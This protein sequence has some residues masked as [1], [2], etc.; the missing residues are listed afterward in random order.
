MDA[1]I[2]IAADSVFNS[3]LTLQSRLYAQINNGNITLD[4]IFRCT[5]C[6][7]EAKDVQLLRGL[8][9]PGCASVSKQLTVSDDGVSRSHVIQGIKTS[10]FRI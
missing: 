7:A 4:L 6:I 5:I 3:D 8:K 9:K 10:S 2:E 1:S